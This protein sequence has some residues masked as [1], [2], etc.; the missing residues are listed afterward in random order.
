MQ[1]RRSFVERRSKP[2]LFPPLMIVPRLAY[3]C[4]K[5]PRRFPR[6]VPNRSIR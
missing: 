6:L 5:A 3:A 1:R 2:D 4:R